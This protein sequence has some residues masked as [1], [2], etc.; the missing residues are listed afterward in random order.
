MFAEST[1]N[2]RELYDTKPDFAM[3]G[4]DWDGFSTPLVEGIATAYGEQMGIPFDIP[5]FILMYRKDL[6]DKHGLEVPTTM[7]AFTENT[8]L[9]H[10][11]EFGNGIYG[12]TGQLEAGHY[13]LECDWTAWLWAHGGSI[14]NKQQRFSG[15]DEQ[16]MDGL[17]YMLELM[18]YMPPEVHR[19][20]PGTTK[21]SVHG[22]TERRPTSFQL[23][24]VRSERW[25]ATTARSATA[26]I[27]RRHAAE[28]KARLRSLDQDA[29]FGEI[30]HISATRAVH[31]SY[32]LRTRKTLMPPGC[33]CNG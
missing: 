21:S 7:D 16:G 2:P 1:I 25:T 6:Y 18:N 20:G 22:S 14:F 19:M 24:P 31:R 29:G 33:S 30:P 15:H 8:R 32:S 13:S 5:I 10:E 12:T 27:E 9:L 26:F 28:G 17:R 23:G 3:P 11:A 4:Y